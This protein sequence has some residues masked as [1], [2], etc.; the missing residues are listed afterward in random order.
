M[1]TRLAFAV[2]CALALLLGGHGAA[3]ENFALGAKAGTTGLGL[4]GTF[5]MSEAF[6]LRG[7][8][9]AFDYSTDIEENGI[10]YDGDLELSNLGLFA[11]WHPFT[12]AFRVSVGGVQSGNAFGG[13]ADGEL[14]V[15]DNTYLAQLQA[16]VDW[17]GFAP[18]LGIGWG[19]AVGSAGWSF[20]FD[21]GVMFTGEPTV[22]LTGTVD[23]P[24][25]QAEFEDDLA[26]EEEALRG[27]LEDAK[28]YPVINL[29]VA[30]RF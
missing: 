16:D 17:D 28:Y 18:Y 29:G 20:S 15:G 21:L 24:L 8:F 3:A 27:E 10:Q 7:G 26:R 4:E 13:S 6:N 23:D 14:D 11:D 30:Y 1:K 12:G 25:L 22:S 5:R 2:P 19:N 9:Y